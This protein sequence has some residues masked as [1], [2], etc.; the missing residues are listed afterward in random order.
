MIVLLSAKAS[1]KNNVARV[2][3]STSPR[4]VASKA[5]LL[6]WRENSRPNTS[7]HQ[8]QHK[9]THIQAV[10]NQWVKTTWIPLQVHQR[11]FVSFLAIFGTSMAFFALKQSI[12]HT[13]QRISMATTTGNWKRRFQK[14]CPKLMSDP[15]F[16]LTRS[17]EGFFLMP[18]AEK[19]A[20]RW[21]AVLGRW[22]FWVVFILGLFWRTLVYNYK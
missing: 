14:V 6:K 1:T 17:I 19:M 2:L 13:P 4:A 16:F 22:R 9:K 12:S 3:V 20:R 8:M 21:V 15:G 10:Q 7:L 5:I 18:S 11:T